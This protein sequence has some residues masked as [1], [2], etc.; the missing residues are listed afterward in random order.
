MDAIFPNRCKPVSEDVPDAGRALSKERQSFGY[1]AFTVTGWLGEA[2]EQ[3]AP[4]SV[5]HTR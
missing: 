5:M 4:F 2:F 3:V 1:G